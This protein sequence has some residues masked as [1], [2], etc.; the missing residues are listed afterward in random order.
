MF[1]EP[2]SGLFK[3]S[4][5]LPFAVHHVGWSSFSEGSAQ[6]PFQ[7]LDLAVSFAQFFLQADFFGFGVHQSFERQ[8]DFYAQDGK[9]HGVLRLFSQGFGYLKVLQIQSCQKGDRRSL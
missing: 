4:Q 6:Q 9:R 7:S 5:F 8:I 3:G 2:G 1:S